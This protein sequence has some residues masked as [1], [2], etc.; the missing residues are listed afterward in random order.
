MRIQVVS[1]LHLEF[2]N[3][4]PALAPEADA[5][6]VAGD[7]A[8]IRQP[9]LLGD[10]VEAWREAEHI[11]Y[12]PGN[13]E[14]YGSD[15]D[16]GRRRLAGQCGIH[17]VTLLD[18]GAVAI[19]G[20]RFIGA[21]LWTDFR[22]HGIAAEPGAH[23]A[24]LGLSDFDTAIRH[25]PGRFTT[26]ESARRHA[27]DRAFI[28]RELRNVR[29]TGQT[30]VVITH[31]A[32]TPQSVAPQFKGDPCNGAF[33]SDLEALIAEHQ[34]ALWVHGHMHDPVDVVLGKTRV[35]CNPAGY[36]AYNNEQRGYA[37]QLCVEIAVDG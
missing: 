20:V 27:A 30:A 5:L 11:L 26:F 33:A 37:P 29:E 21:T 18:P 35:L 4:I 12:V 6:V 3:P 15:I 13:H 31:H 22:L 19:A 36:R 34:P 17:G 24:A 23:R 7:L 2:G 28:E 32:P 16:E 1:D 10:A 8:P 9:W 25:G 14:F